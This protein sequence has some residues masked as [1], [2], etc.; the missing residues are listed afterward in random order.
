MNEHDRLTPIGLR[1]ERGLRW[2]N[3]SVWGERVARWLG[4][5]PPPRRC[6]PCQAYRARAG[7]R[8]LAY[9]RPPAGARA[10]PRA[11]SP[12]L[13]AGAPARRAPLGL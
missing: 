12:T 10:R 6:R 4:S 11:L 9:Q 5:V 2:S 8:R 1:R 7:P 13:F 3:D